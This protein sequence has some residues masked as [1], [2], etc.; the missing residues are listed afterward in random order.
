MLKKENYHESSAGH[1]TVTALQCYSS[2]LPLTPSYPVVHQES[3]KLK[4]SHL[5]GKKIVS[6]HSQI[7]NKI[8]AVWQIN[9]LCLLVWLKSEKEEPT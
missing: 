4:K 5:N 9:G 6:L 8:T 7:D 1:T 3:I 2:L